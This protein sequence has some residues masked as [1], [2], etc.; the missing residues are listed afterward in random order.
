MTAMTDPIPA[1]P[2]LL[3]GLLRPQGLGFVLLLP[4][5]G[6][7]FGHWSW[8]LHLREGPAFLTLLAAWACLHAGTM[9]LNAG[10]D[11]DQGEVL[12]GRA[13]A[14]P[15]HLQGFATAALV[16]APTLAWTAGAVPFLCASGC[17]LLAVLYSSP[18]TAWKAHPIGGPVVNVLGY[19]VLS[20][21]AGWW[22]VGVDAGPRTRVVFASM[23]AITLGL[24]FA[25]Q[26]FQQRED[27]ARSYRTLVVTH[28]PAATLLAARLLFG[29][30]FG[31][32]FAITVA[33]WLPRTCL[34]ALPFAVYVDQGFATWRRDIL[35]DA[36][37]ATE[38]RARRLFAALM[39][40]ALLFVI[41]AYAAY[42]G[43]MLDGA[44]PVAGRATAAGFPG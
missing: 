28:G 7:G 19:G 26:A 39:I 20:P 22:L 2:R 30:G 17:A 42:V 33:G 38:E 21:L 16:A 15:D 11:R 13:L 43:Q 3:W 32:L 36:A 34:L 12:W 14:V 6:Y 8:G 31:A 23:A 5:F 44:H 18:H 4:W 29:A 25:A 9:W 24:Y 41:G 40:T 27:A 35:A 10:L 37:N 1:S